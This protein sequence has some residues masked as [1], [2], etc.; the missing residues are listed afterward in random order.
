MLFM[1]NQKYALGALEFD[2]RNLWLE[3]WKET[4]KFLSTFGS[5]SI[6]CEYSRMGRM[7]A[8]PTQACFHTVLAAGD[9][10]S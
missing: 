2:V 7:H 6:K 9:S 10:D 1:P 8:V 3:R 4:P 5:R